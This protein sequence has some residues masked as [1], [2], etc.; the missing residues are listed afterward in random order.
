MATTDADSLKWSAQLGLARPSPTSESLPGDKIL[1][2]GSA[3]EQL[4][5]AATRLVA[6]PEASLPSTSTFDPFNPYSY[7]AERQARAQARD[8][9][10]QLPQP[11]TFRLVN[12]DNGQVVYAGIREFSAAEGE[13]VLSPFLRS[14]LGLGLT[15]GGETAG[16][17]GKASVPRIT[18]H[19]QQLPK[20]TYVRLRPLEAGYDP[21]DWKSLL[22][23]HLRTK[24]TTLTNGEILAVSG[25]R[26]EEFR[27]LIDKVAPEGDGICVVDTDVEVDIEA[28]N[29]E[30]AR[31]TLKRRLAKTQRAGGDGDSSAGGTLELGEVTEGQVLEGDY[32][33]Y[34]IKSWDR[35]R[36]V[37]IELEGVEEG[38]EVDVFVSPL[39]PRQRARPR[40]DEHVIGDVSSCQPKRIR[41]EASNVAMEDAE[42]LWVSVHG[43]GSGAEGAEMKRG[44]RRFRVRAA[45][46]EAEQVE[47]S[48]EEGPARPDEVRCKNCQQWVPARTM[49][50]HENFCLRN[51]TLCPKCQGVFKKSSADWADHW[52]CSHDSAHGNSPASR[53]KHDA[54]AHTPAA[55]PACQEEFP[56]LSALAHHRVTLCPGKLILCRFCHLTVPQEGGPTAE[57]LMAD[58]TPHELADG[59]RTA[60]C[61]LC[62][63]PVRLRDMDAHLRHHALERRSRPTPRTCANVNCGRTLGRVGKDGSV[64]REASTNA[65]GL[66]G[67]CFGPL[68]VAMYDPDGRALRR[69][70]E[71]RYASQLRT[72][73][74]QA[75][76]RNELCR[77]GRERLGLSQGEALALKE[78]EPL[79]RPAMADPSRLYFCV[80]EASQT[81]RGLA[82]FLAAEGAYDEAW[83]V[84]ALEAEGG[85]V[86]RAREWLANWAPRLHEVG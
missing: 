2:P 41:L 84:A 67:I 50:L 38:Q 52:H 22:E 11:L 48:S 44:P 30:Q 37:K 63:K 70:I 61:H 40:E 32:V 35:K 17:S 73:C 66:C 42:A 1:L 7:A 85:D 33:D 12:P 79:L 81:R 78:A 69:R 80:D 83:C 74:S 16:E 77:A 46:V 18:V 21:E 19:A 28:L 75:W 45:P 3:L 14:S 13:V 6:E 68:Y 53:A 43:Y 31:E 34:E 82:M 29:E 58:L 65:L 62:G 57:S 26:G 72:G 59:A 15:E 64:G 5:S 23:R 4:L 71:R 9:Q 54:T 27:F 51:N 20:G 36:G 56:S 55:C 25:G 47:E 76:C 60:D 86:G 39:G 8:L 24:F 49:M 10:Q